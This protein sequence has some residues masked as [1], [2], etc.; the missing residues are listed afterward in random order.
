[1][2]LIYFIAMFPLSL[3][4]EVLELKAEKELSLG[5]FKDSIE[6]Y[7]VLSKD[8]DRS[9]KAEYLKQLAKAYYFDQ[10][11]AKAFDTFLEA[12][13]LTPPP[14]IPLLI[15]EKEKEIYDEALK[16]YLDPK[17]R[18]SE[19]ISVKIRDL[20]G[21]IYRLHPDYAYLG[22]ITAAAYAN[23]GEFNAFFDIF[24]KS[25]LNVPDHYLAYKTKAILHIKLFERAKTPEEKN[26][27]RDAIL[28]NFKEAKI[29][30]RE[31]LSL[32][33]LQIVFASEKDKPN[34]LESN[35]NEILLASM[36]LSR[37]DLSFYLDQLFTYGKL[38][39]AATLLTNARKWYPYSRTLDAAE[40]LLKG[41][42]AKKENNG[43]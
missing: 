8:Q 41:K 16:L 2:K 3:F 29:R 38:D 30:N 24:Y 13:T 6:S 15:K 22:Y 12:L 9:K 11:H 10:E 26:Q 27:E 36:I 1:M 17:E 25:Y 14:K 33:R 4:G 31:D 32:Y 42:I 34:M 20:Y 7:K 43:S 39:L 21:G 18:N 23:L 40:D 35:L 19:I 37:S 28:L 5:Q